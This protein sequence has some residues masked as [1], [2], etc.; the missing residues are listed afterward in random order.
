[1]KYSSGSADGI[2]PP[3]MT[4]G[5]GTAHVAVV[6]PD[7]ML[8]G[9]WTVAVAS[10]HALLLLVPE[11]VRFACAVVIAQLA[12]VDPLAIETGDSTVGAVMVQLADAAGPLMFPPVLIVAAGTTQFATVEPLATLTGL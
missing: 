3:P 12:F 8:T 2:M 11:A 5:D 10:V 4:V 9:D 1:M 6:P 7:A